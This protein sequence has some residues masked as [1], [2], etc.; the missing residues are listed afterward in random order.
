MV[1]PHRSEQHADL[2]TAIKETAWRLITEQ[3]ASSLSLRAIGRELNITAPAIYNYFAR[4]DDLVTALIL[5]AFQ[6]FGEAQRLTSERTPLEPLSQEAFNTRLVALGTA[7]RDWAVANP[8][9]YMLIFGT[10]IPGYTAPADITVPAAG[11]SLV[12]MIETLQA[13][14]HAGLL[15]RYEFAPMTGSLLEMFRAWQAFVGG[16]EP[17]VLYTTLVI[18]T[19]VHGFVS[20]EI[21]NQL[22]SF[23]TNPGEVYRRELQ[24]ICQAFIRPSA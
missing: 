3:G 23:V 5:E 2:P 19:R 20:L 7:F 15:Q 13:A 18:W 10:P 22:P 24:A 6:S 12:P 4:R 11:W 1:R 16:V 17:E 8:Q 9:R 14:D 21:G